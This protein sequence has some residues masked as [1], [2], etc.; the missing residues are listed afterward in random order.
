[1]S[2]SGQAGILPVVRQL[3][4]EDCT[5]VPPLAPVRSVQSIARAPDTAPPKPASD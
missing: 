1:M 4:L 5:A 3:S 2:G